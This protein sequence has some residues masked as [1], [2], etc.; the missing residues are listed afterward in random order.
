MLELAALGN[1]KEEHDGVLK[2]LGIT[3]PL[4]SRREIKQTERSHRFVGDLT[5]SYQ[6]VK[7]SSLINSSLE[8]S[9]MLSQSTLP[10]NISASFLKKKALEV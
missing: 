8:N 9:T 10:P 4:D 2:E 3:E 6:S 1:G 7:Y 5:V